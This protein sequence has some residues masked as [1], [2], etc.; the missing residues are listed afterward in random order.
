MEMR[1]LKSKEERKIFSQR[2]TEARAQ[3]ASGYRGICRGPIDNDARLR[4]A[5]I[6]ALFEQDGALADAMVAGMAIHDLE[7][8]PQSCSMPDLS[9]LPAESVF[10]C[11]DHWSLARG[12]GMHMWCAAAIYLARMKPSA[13]VV[14]LAVN[15][16]AHMG[17]YTTMGF[18]PA[19]DPLLYPYLET[20]G[21]N[22]WV[23]PMLLEGYALHKLVLAASRVS[24]QATPECTIARFDGSHRLR[25][26]RNRDPLPAARPAMSPPCGQVPIIRHTA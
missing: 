9:H 18:V 26:L 17:F 21:E 20:D 2:V 11:G 24:V 4:A 16:P 1:V 10:E 13:V 8:F 15:P 22:P 25:P 6:L 7:A 5:T 3:F 12:A 23:Q 14:Y 19:G